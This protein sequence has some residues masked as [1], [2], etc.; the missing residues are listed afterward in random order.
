MGEPELHEAAD[1]GRT[2]APREGGRALLDVSNAIV[3]L[4]KAYHGKGPTKARSFL[5][6][7]VLVVVLEGG[8]TR[9]EE[10]LL[11]HGFDATVAQGRAAMQQ[12]I[13]LEMRQVVER[14]ME[15]RVRSYLSANEPREQVQAEIFVLDP[16]QDREAELIHR[17][18]EAA[19]AAS[20]GLY[21]EHRALLEEQ[22]QASREMRRRRDEA[23]RARGRD[24]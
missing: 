20:R 3:G 22:R 19:R 16:Y 17:R 1:V 2:N 13:A 21:E 15:R 14:I 5:N 9:G 7:D 24:T 4:Y 12:S 23:R 18:A 6:Q 11:H 8:L 10:T